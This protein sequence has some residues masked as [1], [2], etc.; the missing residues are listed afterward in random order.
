M[1]SRTLLLLAALVGLGASE[2]VLPCYFANYAQYR[3]GIGRF[4]PEN[5]QAGLCTHIF[6]GYATIN[7]DYSIAVP[8]DPASDLTRNNVTG[9]YG[10]VNNLKNK[11]PGLKTVLSFG[12]QGTESWK[13]SRVVADATRRGSF[14]STALEL[15]KSYG[16]DGI[17]I[18]WFYPTTAD[19]SNF[20]TF[21]KELKAAA[22]DLLVTATVS[23]HLNIAQNS[24]DGV[25]LAASLDYVNVQSFDYAGPWNRFVGLTSPLFDPN[26]MS[27]SYILNAYNNLGF[28][29]SQILLGVTAVGPTWFLD[30]PNFV[31]VGSSGQP[32]TA[33]PYSNTNGYAAYYEVC[34]IVVQ[35]H[36]YWQTPQQVP[37]IVFGSL[38][39]SYEDA[40]S[41][42]VKMQFVREQG[43]GGAF[44]SNL[45]FD[46]FSGQCAGRQRYPLATAMKNGLFS[47]APTPKPSGSP[48]TQAPAPTQKPI[49]A[50]VCPGNGYFSDPTDCSRYFYCSNGQAYPFVCPLNTWW[51]ESRQGCFTAQYVV[52]FQKSALEQKLELQ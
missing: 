49:P 27:V 17:D 42:A 40:S 34:N 24:Y 28:N 46:D 47:A 37:F 43:Y 16:F 36:R 32:L 44:L 19:K 12:G 21:I 25:A 6:F 2:F 3:Q 5:Y 52:C 51:S 48:V 22:G 30:N 41:I 45:D 23:G 26:G 8:S 10:R 50:F 20:A 33:Y 39:F 38:W 31:G 18:S 13:F 4:V 35:S 1:T 11:Q 9:L 15:V 29:K 14:I 7:P